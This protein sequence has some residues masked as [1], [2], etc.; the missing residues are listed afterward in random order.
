MMHTATRLGPRRAPYP[1]EKRKAKARRA[2]HPSPLPEG[3]GTGRAPVLAPRGRGPDL[4]ALA[5]WR[6]FVLLLGRGRGSE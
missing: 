4:G 1:L 3:E 2:P 6:F 5:S